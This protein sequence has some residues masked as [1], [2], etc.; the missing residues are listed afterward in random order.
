LTAPEYRF[1]ALRDRASVAGVLAVAVFV[2]LA[3]SSVMRTWSGTWD[4]F[5]HERATLA[6]QPAPAPLDFAARGAGVDPGVLDFFAARLRPG[7]RYTFQ[8]PANLPA[9]SFQALIE[10]SALALLP[11]IR[12]ED[13][14][15]ANVV[16]SYNADPRTLNLGHPSEQD[17]AL[18]FFITRLD[19]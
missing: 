8:V 19:L 2:A 1:V 14:N 10:I 3:L 13:L 11:A 12:V 15:S 6:A 7:D 17:G 18:P 5:K 16:L 9:A 4:T